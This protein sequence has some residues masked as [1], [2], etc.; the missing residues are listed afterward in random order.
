MTD[1]IRN[2]DLPAFPIS[3]LSGKELEEGF[4]SDYQ[5]LTKL[6]YASIQIAAG[7]R[8]I[9]ERSFDIANQLFDELEKE[10]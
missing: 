10:S 8:G 1:K 9:T 7:V 4:W 3:K 5:G 2:R 6:E